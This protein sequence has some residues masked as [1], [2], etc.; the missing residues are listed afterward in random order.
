MT[1][2]EFMRELT[3]IKWSIVILGERQPISIE[4]L[5]QIEY[6][7]LLCAQEQ[8]FLVWNPEQDEIAFRI[9]YEAYKK[10]LK[11]EGLI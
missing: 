3:A 5:K 8:S 11:E 4:Y 1:L 9:E 2:V 7:L 6:E 10:I